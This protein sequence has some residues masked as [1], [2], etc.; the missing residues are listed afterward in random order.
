MTQSAKVKEHVQR[1]LSSG[2]ENGHLW[3]GLAPPGTHP[4]LL[5]TTKGRK[6]GELWTTPLV[7]GRD[8][9]SFVVVVSHGGRPTHPDG[10]LSPRKPW[11]ECSGWCRP[12]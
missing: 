9:V 2:G 12:V 11:C 4:C 5:L 8:G 7:C 6:S 1:Y 3:D 10:I